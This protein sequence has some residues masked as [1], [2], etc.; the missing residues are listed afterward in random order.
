MITKLTKE[1]EKL[2]PVYRD[3]W[4]EIGLSTNRICL[5]ETKEIINHFYKAIMEYKK[6]PLVIVMPNVLWGWLAACL[7]SQVRSQ[8]RSQVGSQVWSQVES[9]VES[10]VWSQV[11]SQVES[12]VRSQ[13]E[14]Q[15]RPF[16][17]PYTSGCLD[18][19]YL[20]FYDY[21]LSAVLHRN[22]KE[23][24]IYLRTSLL[25]PFY[26]FPDCCILTEKPKEIKM[27]QGLLHNEYGP[28]IYYEGDLKIYSLH[29]VKVPQWLVET[30]A[31]KIDPKKVLEIKNA[32][33]RR[34]FVR[35]IGI[36]RVWHK[37]ANVIDKKGDYE[38][39][40]ID[41]GDERKRPYLKMLNPSIGTWHVECV[42]PE[43]KTVEQALN[44][45]KPE[46]MRKIKTSENGADWYQQGDVVIVPE[47]IEF[48]K[49]EP[50]ILT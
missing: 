12:Q 42:G 10:Q 35:K 22:P 44:F 17:W 48:I 49:P 15:V 43:C 25:A 33:V 24:N 23:W 3:K 9:Q 21:F 34:E 26:V 39:G 40:L 29:G 6:S 4:L 46:W 18:A 27:A 2:L 50:I 13:V 30:K 11:W 31:E 41:V 28:S 16:W 45:R 1:Q 5:G 36:D 37:L 19:T 32:E 38:V 14:S 20:C 7:W 47:N 8:V